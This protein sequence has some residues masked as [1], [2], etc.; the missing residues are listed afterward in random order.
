[1]DPDEALKTALEAAKSIVEEANSMYG[2]GPTNDSMTDDAV[3]LAEAFLSLHKRL[4]TGGGGPEAWEN[5]KDRNL[6]TVQEVASFRLA[7]IRV[8]EQKDS[9]KFYVKARVYGAIAAEYQKA[10][11]AFADRGEA[12]AQAVLDWRH[13]EGGG[14]PMKAVEEIGG[15]LSTQD[16][17]EGALASRDEWVER[18]HAADAEGER[19]RLELS[20]EGQ[21]IAELKARI[22]NG[23]AA[24]REEKTARDWLAREKERLEGVIRTGGAMYRAERATMGIPK[25]RDEEG[26]PILPADIRALAEE[27]AKG[28]SRSLVDAAQTFAKYLLGK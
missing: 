18:A 7:E 17:L 27:I 6:R 25:G 26:Q 24:H 28:Q 16:R 21:V 15:L 1:M 12:L 20:G 14:V 4:T 11:Q 3:D 5:E 2:E 9:G 8:L 13:S 22:E 10:L 23:M 19:L